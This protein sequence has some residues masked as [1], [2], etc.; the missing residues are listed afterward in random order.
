MKNKIKFSVLERN[1]PEPA[2]N[3]FW[4]KNRTHDHPSTKIGIKIE[5]EPVSGPS[6][7]L[8][9]TENVSSLVYRYTPDNGNLCRLIRKHVFIQIRFELTSKYIYYYKIF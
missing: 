4:Y 1:D 2:E 3:E 7:G 6:S 8:N 5:P 9:G